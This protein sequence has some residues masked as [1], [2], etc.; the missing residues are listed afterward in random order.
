MPEHVQRKSY[1]LC[2]RLVVPYA[3]LHLSVVLERIVPRDHHRILRPVVQVVELVVADLHDLLGAVSSQA[4]DG[5][6]AAGR[7]L[8][9]RC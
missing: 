6:Q 2:H 7:G 9:G 4:S 1:V 5:I 3:Y 8:K